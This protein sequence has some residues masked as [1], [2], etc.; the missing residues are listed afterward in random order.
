MHQ[1]DESA[2]GQLRALIDGWRELAALDGCPPAIVGCQRQLGE[3][4]HC[5]AAHLDGADRAETLARLRRLN[6][7]QGEYMLALIPMLCRW[8]EPPG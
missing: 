3:V 4:V 5:L 6:E 1:G 8:L 2:L 7:P